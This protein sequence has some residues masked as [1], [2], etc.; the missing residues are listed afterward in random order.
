MAIKTGLHQRQKN[1]I[2]ESTSTAGQEAHSVVN[3]DGSNVMSG[4]LADLN[5][6]NTALSTSGL[7][8]KPTGGGGDF[9]TAYG[10]ATRVDLT[11]L[12]TFHA[13]FASEDIVAI[14]Q[15][16]TDGSVTETYTRD[17]AAMT[18]AANNITV[19]GA[20]FVATDT[21][22]VYT[23]IP[24]GGSGPFFDSDGDNTAQVLKASGGDLVKVVAYN[25]NTA[26]AFVQLFDT[27][28]GSVTVG[29]TPPIYVI[30][31]LGQGSSVIDFEG[32]FP[33]GT[34]ITYACT[35]TATGNGDPT[36]GLVISANYN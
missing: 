35:T 21:F 24:R 30:P 7:I 4:V 27:A 15:I 13:N 12:P 34:A 23:N 31:V 11:G 5:V 20:A 17:D 1:A 8:G 18:V 19:T 3:P 29:T 6:D 28:A 26:D 9:T 32:T 14:V 22:V 10:T 16:A 25:S 33:F 2:I 36:T